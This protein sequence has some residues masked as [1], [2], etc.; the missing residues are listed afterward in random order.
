MTMIR[1]RA[2]KSSGPTPPSLVSFTTGTDQ[3][4]TAMIEGYYNGVLSL[5]DIQSVW[6]VGDTRDISLSAMEAT[7]VSESH[8]A[9]T[10]TIQIL[11]FD[12]DTL[13][14]SE[15]QITKALITV[16]LKDCLT[17]GATYG[18]NDTEIGSMNSTS[19]NAGGWSS[20]A[21]RT[22]CNDVFYNALPSY[23]KSLVKNV[24][25]LT[26]A[27]SQ[28]STINTTSDKCFLPSE[29]EFCNTTNNS[30]SG[31]GSFYSW[32]TDLE[33]RRKLPKYTATFTYN[34]N[35]LC[36][37]S[38]YTSDNTSFVRIIQSSSSGK[39]GATSTMGIAPAFC[40]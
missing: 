1:G 30:F 26:S 5:N 38:P 13:T 20:C 8:R 32:Y 28:S 29:I 21:R 34:T 11:D 17:D 33:H 37:R 27:G 35:L 39:W 22:W 7:G 36:N 23:I 9:Q 40:L 4:I 19:T 31:E 6:S 25:K 15:G 3:E 2:L 14:T 18:Q 24:D 10:V 16:D 12:H